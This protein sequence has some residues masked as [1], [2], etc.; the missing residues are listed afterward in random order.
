MANKISGGNIL[1][2]CN[3]KEC[4]E[5]C[6]AGI[7]GGLCHHTTFLEFAKNWDHVP[8]EEDLDEH[9]E[10]IEIEGLKTHWVEKEDQNE[11]KNS[12]Y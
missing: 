7:V 10:K 5:K 1:Y 11:N 3:G 2:L 6:N 12:D 9:F 8:S 4:G